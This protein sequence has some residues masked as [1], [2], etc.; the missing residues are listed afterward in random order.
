MEEQAE[1]WLEYA[2]K[3]TLSLYQEAAKLSDYA[4]LNSVKKSLKRI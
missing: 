1:Y 3:L 2:H 4:L